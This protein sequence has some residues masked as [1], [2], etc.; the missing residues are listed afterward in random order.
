M[1]AIQLTNPLVFC[2]CPDGTAAF[3]KPRPLRIVTSGPYRGHYCVRRYQKAVLV[4][5]ILG[6]DQVMVDLHAERVPLTM[7]RTCELT[8]LPLEFSPWETAI[9]D[10]EGAVRH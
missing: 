7:T 8:D 3:T 6:S 9:P 1:S 4:Q 2:L 5:G 10:P